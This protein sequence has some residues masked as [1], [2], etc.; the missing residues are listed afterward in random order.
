MNKFIKYKKQYERVQQT[1]RSFD[2]LNRKSL[3]SNVTHKIENE[4]LCNLF[5]K[6]LEVS[7]NESFL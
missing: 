4:I 1:S 5:T 3:Q 7:K 2:K 6:F